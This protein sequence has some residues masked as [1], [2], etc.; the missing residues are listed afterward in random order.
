MAFMAVRSSM[1]LFDWSLIPGYKQV[2]IHQP[3]K[4][5]EPFDKRGVVVRT[6]SIEQIRQ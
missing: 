6:D 4:S 3:R 1:N 5:L 2:E